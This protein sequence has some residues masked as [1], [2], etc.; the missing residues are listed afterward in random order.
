MTIGTTHRDI[1]VLSS[2][3]VIVRVR[4]I[5]S[6]IITAWVSFIHIRNT[7]V[8][9]IVLARVSVIQGFTCALVAIPPS[10]SDRGTFTDITPWIESGGCI[11]WGT[12]NTRNQIRRGPTR[13]SSARHTELVTGGH[14]TQYRVVHNGW[15]P[16]LR[17]ITL[18]QC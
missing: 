16:S 12:F 8:T 11:T 7:V 4:I 14:I 3:R 9:L 6:T 2:D 17:C 1:A 18:A 5:A 10:R 15:E 13:R